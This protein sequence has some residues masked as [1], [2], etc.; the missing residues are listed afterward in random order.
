MPLLHLRKRPVESWERH[1]TQCGLCCYE[2]APV[3]GG[4]R[5]DLARP[6]P[7][8]DTS[9]R[10]CKVYDRRFAVEASCSK[11][12]LLHALFGRLMPL[13][14]GYVRRFRRWIR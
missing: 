1:C 13:T 9:T 3:A 5:V 6:C 7:Y 10:R 4:I 11:V 12:N 8:L 2:R 14:C